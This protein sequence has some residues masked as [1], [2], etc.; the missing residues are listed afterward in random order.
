[1]NRAGD[2][3]SRM[4]PTTAAKAVKAAWNM[5]TDVVGRQAGAGNVAVTAARSPKLSEVGRALVSIAIQARQG[6]GLCLAFHESTA[7]SAG[8][9]EVLI[10]AARRGTSPDLGIATL[11]EIALAIQASSTTITA[12][13]VVVLLNAGY[14]NRE[15]ADAVLVVAQNVVLGSFHVITDFHND[16]AVQDLGSC[17]GIGTA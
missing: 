5:V 6:C 3:L 12:G 8:A 2:P 10:E 11:I 7:R 4:G 16:R 17:Q 13:Q 9:D 1:M 15:I 14:S